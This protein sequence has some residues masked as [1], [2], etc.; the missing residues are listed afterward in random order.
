M[1]NY[2]LILARRAAQRG[3]G[4]GLVYARVRLSA[5]SDP[6]TDIVVANLTHII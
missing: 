2:M 4:F 5:F 1:S 3:H 6:F